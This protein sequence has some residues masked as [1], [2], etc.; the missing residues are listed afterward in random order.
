M[1]V[2]LNYITLL[3]HSNYKT[4]NLTVKPIF[5]RM[6]LCKN[7]NMTYRADLAPSPVRDIISFKIGLLNDSFTDLAKLCQR[8]KYKE[9][10]LKFSSPSVPVKLFSIKKGNIVKLPRPRLSFIKWY[11]THLWWVFGSHF[12]VIHVYIMLTFIPSQTKLKI[13]KFIFWDL[14]KLYKGSML[15][16][17]DWCIWIEMF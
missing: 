16:F 9:I 8:A 17:K 7:L 11:Y 3:I 2:R 5:Y 6:N 13:W 1:L 14:Q 15:V 4:S 12:W 10:F